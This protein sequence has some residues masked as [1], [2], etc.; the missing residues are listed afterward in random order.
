MVSYNATTFYD[1]DRMLRGVFAAARDITERKRLDQVLRE[2][3]I[4]LESAWSVAEKTNLAKSEFLANMSH[5]L[6]TPLNSVIGFSEILQDR[7]FGPMNEKQQE[8]VK[9]ILD[10]GRH[11]LSLINDVLD[12]SKVESGKMELD[13]STFSLRELLDAT[14]MMLKEKALKGGINLRL[15]ITPEADVIIEADERKLKQIMF[16][17]VSNAVKFTPPNGT[18]DVS[19]IREE[20]FIEITVTDTGVGIKE[21][22]VPKLFQPFTQLESVYTKEFEGTGL[23]L[24]LTRQLVE[25]HGGRVWVES[26]FG[27]GSRFCFNFPLA[28]AAAKVPSPN[29]PDTIP[30]SGNTI[31]LIED[32]P[33]TQTSL[34]C[35]LQCKG[36]RVLRAN[37]GMNGISMARSDK[38]DLIILD[39]MMPGVSGFD[40]ADHLNDENT[41]PN[42]PILVL[43]AMDLSAADRTRLSGKVWRIAEKGTLSTL[44]LISLVESAIGVKITGDNHHVTQNSD[45]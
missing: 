14:V 45:C 33:L 15:D 1:R 2:K 38:P 26:K 13:L 16:N 6:R 11:L 8:Y 22:D 28:Q 31:L 41:A 44:N 17:L 24:A 10:S 12:L 43:T 29:R 21:K 36:Y 5:E 27:V 30:G 32:D 37:N 3:N 9:N 40:V 19:A 18:V 39:L 35:A 42:T 20:H 7:M 34:K 25:L 4:E 23:G